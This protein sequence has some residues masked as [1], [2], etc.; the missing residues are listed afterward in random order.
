LDVSVHIDE[1]GDDLFHLD[2]SGHFHQSL[3]DSLHLV[4]LGHYY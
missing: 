2:N 4:D 1:L 3:L